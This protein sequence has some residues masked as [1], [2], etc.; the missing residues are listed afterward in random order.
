MSLDIERTTESIP[1]IEG[2][3]IRRD[4]FSQEA[5]GILLGAQTAMSKVN[6]SN[7]TTAHLL[8]GFSSM[9][10]KKD[11]VAVLLENHGISLDN[12]YPEAVKL[13]RGTGEVVPAKLNMAVQAAIR[14]AD[15]LRSK[16]AL[17]LPLHLFAGLMEIG[18]FHTI[19][20]TNLGVEQTQLSEE[21]LALLK[22]H[23]YE[24]QY[25]KRY[26]TPRGS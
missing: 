4:I 5:Y 24:Y 17:I 22:A 2:L 20:L 3:P 12:V 25:D 23:S 26:K 14:K 6:L 1:P 13:A 11:P 21:A 8:L 10:D 18:G 16:E 19:I 9:S 7:I 15:N